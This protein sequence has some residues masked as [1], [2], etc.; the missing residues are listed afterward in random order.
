MRNLL[1]QLYLPQ[2]RVQKSLRVCCLC[3]YVGLE[4]TVG[5]V[6]DSGQWR[7]NVKWERAKRYWTLWGEPGMVFA[8]HHLQPEWC[9]WPEE[10]LAS[11]T[12]ELS[13]GLREVEGEQAGGG[14][15]PCRWAGRCASS[16]SA[17]T[18][19]NIQSVKWQLLHSAT[20]ILYKFSSGHSQPRTTLERKL[21]E[22]IP[23]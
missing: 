4:V 12:T 14:W 13:G 7:L 23:A 17:S 10:K 11:F 9:R 6:A 8:Y 2:L 1:Y 15:T 16:H 18:Y 19:T 3:R 20:Q 5:C 22:A 21:W